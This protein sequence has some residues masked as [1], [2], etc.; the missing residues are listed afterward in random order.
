MTVLDNLNQLDFSVLFTDEE[1]A[2]HFAYDYDLLYDGGTCESTH[3][4]L[5]NYQIISDS[6]TKTGFRLRCD[7][8]GKTKSLFHN[9]IFTRSQL[10]V[11]KI[12]HLLYTWALEYPCGLAAYEVDVSESTV[13]NFFQAFRQACKFYIDNE[14]QQ[15]IG[16]VGYNVELDESI[17]SKRKNNVGRVL[18]EIW[19]FGGVCRE[20]H[21]RFVY[22]VDR[23]DSATLLPIIQQMVLP[24]SIVHTDGWGAYNGIGTLPQGYTHQVVNHSLNFVDPLTGCHT[25][26]V[27]R[28][29]REVKRIRRRY[30]G[31]KRVDVDYH[32]AEYL[33]REARN[34]NKSNAFAEAII[35]VGDCPFY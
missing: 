28:M 3:G 23:R 19:V 30:E 10:P 9:S 14:G 17:I 29:W 6:S 4:C 33:W 12:L 27:E 15:P 18:Q 13:S 7:V 11:N 5:G 8:C 2:L 1:Q 16:G 24:G 32:L 22:K 20:T 26:T 25:Q 35:L 31:I 34:V 21:E